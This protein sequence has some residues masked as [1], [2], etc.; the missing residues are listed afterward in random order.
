MSGNDDRREGVMTAARTRK[1]SKHVFSA[2]AAMFFLL[3]NFFPA[4]SII[5]A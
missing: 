5:H 4:A 3:V 1:I 2:A